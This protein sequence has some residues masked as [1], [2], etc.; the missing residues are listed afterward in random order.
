GRDIFTSLTVGENL[1]LAGSARRGGSYRADMDAVLEHFPVLRQRLD[2]SAGKLSG[3][4]QQQLAIARALLTKP[5]LLLLD[6]P[7]LGLAPRV[8]D[9]VYRILARL[10][11]DGLTMLVVEQNATRA[12]AIADRTYVLRSGVIELSGRADELRRSAR[13]EEAYFGFGQEPEP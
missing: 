5:R 7:S 4:E 9:T 11:S 1:R 10:R 13:F 12:L 3:G 2:S 8:I 6:E